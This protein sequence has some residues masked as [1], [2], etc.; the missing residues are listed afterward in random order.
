MTLDLFNGHCYYQF[1]ILKKG[2]NI[3][4]VDLNLPSFG[5][6]RK[7]LSLCFA[8]S[9]IETF[10]ISISTYLF[11]PVWPEFMSFSS[12]TKPFSSLLN[13]HGVILHR[14]LKISS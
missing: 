14:A 3:P 4:V 8:N 13:V 6:Q 2:K 7:E 9:T 12:F 1:Q 11:L 10:L 5:P